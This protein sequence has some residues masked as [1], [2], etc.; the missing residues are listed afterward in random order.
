MRTALATLAIVL[1]MLSPAASADDVAFKLDANLF[2]K[3]ATN[4]QNFRRCFFKSPIPPIPMYDFPLY[5]GL[6]PM[7]ISAFQALDSR[8]DVIKRDF[9]FPVVIAPDAFKIAPNDSH[10]LRDSLWPMTR[11]SFQRLDCP[12]ENDANEIFSFCIASN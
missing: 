4:D 10:S 1:G 2:E 6:W 11:E 9:S 3:S 7:T 5:E 12:V 8:P